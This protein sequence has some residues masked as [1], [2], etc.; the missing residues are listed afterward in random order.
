MKILRQSQEL[1]TPV[2]FRRPVHVF[3]AVIQLNVRSEISTGVQFA[4]EAHRRPNY[5]QE[6]S[7][8]THFGFES[9]VSRLVGRSKRSQ[10]I[11]RVAPGGKRTPRSVIALNTARL[12]SKRTC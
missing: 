7:E 9:S 11:L 2:K 3:P 5:R 1:E 10:P 8:A 6:F 4:H 12:F